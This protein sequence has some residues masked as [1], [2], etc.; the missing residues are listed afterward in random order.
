[1]SVSGCTL[2]SGGPFS[3]HAHT[4][5]GPAQ[6]LK[7]SSHPAGHTKIRLTVSAGN[8]S[9]DGV[10][11]EL[12]LYNPGP[13]TSSNRLRGW[14]GWCTSAGV[15]RGSDTVGHYNG[16]QNAADCMQL[17]YSCGATSIAAGQAELW[18]FKR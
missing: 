7:L 16:A 14:L 11:G 9:N 1:M 17:L 13:A 10:S 3:S 2:I 6:H 8:G 15:L 12:R 5:P 18:S 4:A